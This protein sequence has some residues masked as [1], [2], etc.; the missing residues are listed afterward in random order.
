MVNFGWLTLKFSRFDSRWFY[1][2]EIGVPKGVF[3]EP[4][5]TERF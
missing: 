5:S 2:G 1:I 4:L 3:V